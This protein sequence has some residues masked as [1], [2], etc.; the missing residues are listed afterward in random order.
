MKEIEL[1]LKA[2]EAQQSG[3]AT[4]CGYGWR[5]RYREYSWSRDGGRCREEC[6]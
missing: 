3:K 6:C 2:E 4:I 5:D 1:T